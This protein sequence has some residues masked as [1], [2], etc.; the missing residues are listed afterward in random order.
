MQKKRLWPFRQGLAL[1]ATPVILAVLL[2]AAALSSRFL[3][4]PAAT[5]EGLVLIGILILSVVP[6]VLAILDALLAGGGAVEIAGFKLN[7]AQVATASLTSVQMPANLGGIR[8]QAITDT[9]SITILKALR[10]AGSSDIIVIDLGSGGEWWETRLLVLLAG[11]VRLRHPEIVVF[12]ATDRSVERGFQGWA[13]PDDLLPCLLAA[14]PRY[15]RSYWEAIAAASQWALEPPPP[16]PEPPT[17]V[18]PPAP[19]QGL[20]KRREG[21]R[22]SGAGKTAVRNELAA[23]QAFAAELGNEV[24]LPTTPAGITI[25]RLMNL[26]RPVLHTSAIDERDPGD[27]QLKEFLA[28]T[29]MYVAT[30]RGR[31]YQQ[32]VSRGAGLNAIVRSIIEAWPSKAKE[33]NAAS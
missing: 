10:D 25:D 17:P 31:E 7:F 12:V 3:N 2:V 8:G 16:D 27:K 30:T 11:A 15:R 33:G 23:E 24:E 29:E 6:L 21:M 22:R 28:G 32:L 18:V 14:D 4:W 19:F 9:D 20:A 13:R 5:S 1:L 26:F